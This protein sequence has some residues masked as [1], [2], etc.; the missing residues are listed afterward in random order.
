MQGVWWFVLAISIIVYIL[1]AWFVVPRIF[2]KSEYEVLYSSDRGLRNF[3]EKNGRSIVY[4]PKPEYR[5]FVSQYILSERNGKKQ[6]LCKLRGNAARLDYDIVLFN[7]DDKVFNVL[8]V[9][10]NVTA[11][12][13]THT[14]E[15]PPQTSYAALVLHSV[16]GRPL[17]D[18]TAEKISWRTSASFALAAA[19][20]AIAEIFC[21][22]L[23]LA[24]LFGD[25]FTEGFMISAGSVLLS[26]TFGLIVA[27]IHIAS[28]LGYMKR[29]QRKKRITVKNA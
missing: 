7:C 9:K 29:K 11:G 21:S 10:E 1:L 14:I 17:R 22:K 23:C 6:L 24:V 25:V 5:K 26:I 2:F 4:E 20:L 12:G 3:K 15:V 8:N 19:F 18:G 27:A 13:Y 28:V 16:D